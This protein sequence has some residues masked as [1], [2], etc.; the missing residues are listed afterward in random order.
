[1]RKLR[2]TSVIS[3][4]PIMYYSRLTGLLTNVFYE[5]IFCQLIVYAVV[6]AVEQ[7][8]YIALTS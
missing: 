1:M 2:P 5:C 6:R 3:L 8:L 7:N 4:S